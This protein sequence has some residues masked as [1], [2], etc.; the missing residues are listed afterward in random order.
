MTSQPCHFDL[1]M[2][3]AQWQGSGR[4]E[5]LPRGADEIARICAGYAP[6]ETVPISAANVSGSGINRWDALLDQFLAAQAILRKHEPASVLTAGGDCAVD[7][8]VIDYLLRL[9]PD[10]T[11]IWIDSH[12]DAN[13]TK[14]SPSGNFHGMPVSTILGAPPAELQPHLGSALQSRAFRYFWAHVGDQGDWDFQH[15]NELTWLKDD[16]RFPG[17]IH[18][19]FDLDVFDP[20]E[21]PHLA[22]PEKNG[23]TIDAAIAL[24]RRLASENRV[25]GLTITEF[26]PGD[27]AGATAGGQIVSRLIESACGNWAGV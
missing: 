17:P 5:N 14:T 20:A 24:L 11:V 16:E 19:H 6:L 25:V 13:T 8:V 1:A 10:L 23:L 22:Y 2:G 15:E 18:I 3:Y 27:A 26:A 9:Y 7:I 12:L 4:P 21:F